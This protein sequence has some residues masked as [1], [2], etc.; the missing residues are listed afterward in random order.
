MSLLATYRA[1]HHLDQLFAALGR[2]AVFDPVGLQTSLEAEQGFAVFAAAYPATFAFCPTGKGGTIKNDCPP[3]RG[4][5]SD[6]DQDRSRIAQDVFTFFNEEL[7]STSEVMWLKGKP[8]EYRQ[9]LT[10]SINGMS[11][12]CLERI[13][14]NV[15]GAI[16]YP[17][18]YQLTYDALSKSGKRPKDGE[19]VDVVAG[20]FGHRGHGQ[21]KLYLNGGTTQSTGPKTTAEIYAHEFA[22]AVDGTQ[23]E[24][25]STPEW[26]AAW[27]REIKPTE[28][29]T[30]YAATNPRDGFAEFGRMIFLDRHDEART[31]FPACWKFWQDKGLI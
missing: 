26:Q 22:H 18:M 5:R 14:Q 9:A 8:A 24:Y 11:Q 17:T 20:A 10:D 3:K 15:E 6:G 19:F 27:E 21:G 23:Y 13:K 2:P 31:K 16:F 25:S 28:W 12:K 7:E 4:L 29:P 30:K 1:T